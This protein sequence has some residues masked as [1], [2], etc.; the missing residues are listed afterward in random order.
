MSDFLEIVNHHDAPHLTDLAWHLH[1]QERARSEATGGI[2]RTLKEITAGIHDSFYRG[3]RYEL[4]VD[5]AGNV[6][7]YTEVS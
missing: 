2:P 5:E 6:R 4:I 3:V 7:S 1:E